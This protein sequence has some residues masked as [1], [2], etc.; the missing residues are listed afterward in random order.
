MQAILAKASVAALDIHLMSDRLK[1]PRIGAARVAAKV[2]KFEAAGYR[3]ASNL[4][5]NPVGVLGP[6]IS[7]N[8]SVANL[9][10]FIP[11][12]TRGESMCC[13]DGDNAWPESAFDGA[14]KA[15][16]DCNQWRAVPTPALPVQFAPATRRDFCHSQAIFNRAFDA[17]LWRNAAATLR[18]ILHRKLT[19]SGAM[20]TAV[21]A[22]RP[23]LFY[24]KAGQVFE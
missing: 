6:I 17:G 11:E 22:A 19:L 5:R 3:A 9:H 23:S 15:S 18:L 14:T 16:A 7:A 4:V 12:P 10:R 2:V 13:I 24:I 8:C 20:R 21:S 1:V